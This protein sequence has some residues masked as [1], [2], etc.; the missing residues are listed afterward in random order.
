MMNKR[1]D[2][3][4]GDKTG[5]L[6]PKHGYPNLLAYGIGIKI[7]KMKLFAVAP[8]KCLDAAKQVN[9]TK[10]FTVGFG[11]R[12]NSYVYIQTGKNITP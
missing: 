10:P 5:N 7:F 6:L 11:E 4:N 8:V 2:S 12:T 1:I 3:P 9:F